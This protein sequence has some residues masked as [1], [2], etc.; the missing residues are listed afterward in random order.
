MKNCR[1]HSGGWQLYT[2][3]HGRLVTAWFKTQPTAAEAR[4]WVRLAHLRANRPETVTAP[5]ADASTLRAD[6]Q[7]YLAL[8]A[9]MPTLRW[10]RDDLARWV[11]AYGAYAR[12]DITPMMVRAQLE[13]WIADG[14]AANTVN[15]R[16][17][18]LANLYTVLDGRHA[19]NPAREVPRYQEPQQPPAALPPAAIAAVLAVMRET[20]TKA[21]LRLMAWT[22]WPHA[23]IRALEP[24]HIRWDEAVYVTAR[25]KGGG[26]AGRWLP[27]L[28]DGWAALRA[29]KRIGAWGP[30]STSSLR[31][32]LRAA[33]QR[34]QRDRTIPPAI[35]AALADVTPYDLR[36][37]FLTLVGLHSRDERAVAALGMHADTRT[38]RRYTE[39]SVDP[40]VAAAMAKVA[41]QV[42]E[43]PR[44]R[45][46]SKKTRQKRR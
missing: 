23:Q 5:A 37:S 32:S 15:H 18:A 10:R 34:V 20:P 43:R 33:A 27:L 6:V 46:Q 16:R 25:R 2:R 41:E 42:A 36:H 26:V 19:R 24:S 1:P 44:R 22:G 3:L 21:R 13:Q 14:Y 35:R 11:D 8:R 45:Q 28:P 31:T 39:A 12:S 7:T 30:F 9:S 4:D 40:R 29:F 38:T 17:S